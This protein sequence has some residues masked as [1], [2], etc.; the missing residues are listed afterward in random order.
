MV[1]ILIRRQSKVANDHEFV[2]ILKLDEMACD[3]HF[4]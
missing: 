3:N 1:S 2:L 4:F